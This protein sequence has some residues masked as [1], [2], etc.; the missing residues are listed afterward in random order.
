MAAADIIIE[1]ESSGNTI[2][3]E[4]AS[5]EIGRLGVGDFFGEMSA[6]LPPSLAAYRRRSRTAFAC[7]ETHL[8][9]L[10]HEDIIELCA[11]RPQI[12]E[13]VIP[14]VNAIAKKLPPTP[15]RRTLSTVSAT[16]SAR[17]GSSSPNPN[18]QPGQPGQPGQGQAR[19]PDAAVLSMSDVHPVL[20]LLEP[21]LEAF[22]E[23]LGAMDE[24]QKAILTK[25][26]QLLAKR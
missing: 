14:Y 8:G 10:S 15:L 24:Q 17:S 18:Q 1:A 4:N 16:S 23:K 2:V 6:L 11:K 26:D 12:A 19:D 25:L 21:R 7:A 3:L 5:K 13:K 20:R 22:D 9:M